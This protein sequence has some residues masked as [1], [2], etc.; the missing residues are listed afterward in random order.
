LSNCDPQTPH[1]CTRRRCDVADTD[2]GSRLIV[3]VDLSQSFVDDDAAVVDDLDYPGY[4]CSMTSE[5]LDW[6]DSVME[7]WMV[8]EIA[9][10]ILATVVV[11]VVEFVEM[12]WDF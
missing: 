4:Y 10:A 11:V 12:L 5:P 8:S 6:I 2:N 9:L 1:W 3:V 7:F